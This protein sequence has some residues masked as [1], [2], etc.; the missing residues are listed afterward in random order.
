[1]KPTLL[2]LSHQAQAVDRER[3]GHHARQRRLQRCMGLRECCFGQFAGQRHVKA[4]LVNHIRVTPLEQHHFLPVTQPRSA[5][6]LKFRVTRRRT[7]LIQRFNTHRRQ[8]AQLRDIP[9][10]SERDEAPKLCELARQ[11]LHRMK[12]PAA[13]NIERLHEIGLTGSLR[14]PKGRL[15]CRVKSVFAGRRRDL[16]DRHGQARYIKLRHALPALQIPS[17][18]RGTNLCQW[19]GH[20]GEIHTVAAVSH[21]L[22]PR[23]TLS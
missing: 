13:Q 6:F 12:R 15:Q 23:T 5:A 4:E 22:S 18:P 10:R 2:I 11:P 19:P 9:F 17:P 14:Q 7:E 16:F 20:W 8:P 1:M 21:D 3:I